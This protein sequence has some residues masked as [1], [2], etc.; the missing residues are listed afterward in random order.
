[1]NNTT[2]LSSSGYFW[3]SEIQALDNCAD[4][5]MLNQLT[6]ARVGDDLWVEFPG[7]STE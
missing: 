1:M 6:I 2:Q 5:T 3:N 4:T 7:P